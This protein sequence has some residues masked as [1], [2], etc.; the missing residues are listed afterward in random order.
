V[1]DHT[2]LEEFADPRNYDQEDTSDTG[3]A[4]YSGLAQKTG[5]QC[6]RLHV[7]RAV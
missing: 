6:L 5:A 1:I 7:G 4:F 2:N 3:V